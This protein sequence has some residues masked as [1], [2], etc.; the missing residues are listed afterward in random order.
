MPKRFGKLESRYQQGFTSGFNHGKNLLLLSTQIQFLRK[1]KGIT[2]EVFSKETNIPED[3]IVGLEKADLKT[4][5]RTELDSLVRIANFCDVTIDVKLKSHFD[6][7]HNAST[8]EVKSFEEEQSSVVFGNG[9]GYKLPEVFDGGYVVGAD[10]HIEHTLVPKDSVGGKS[11]TYI[12]PLSQDG[13]LGEYSIKPSAAV[14]DFTPNLFIVF[15][16]ES[17]GL[18]GQGFAVGWVVIEI[19]D[20]GCDLL[21][22]YCL[23]CDRNYAMGALDDRNWVN[24]NVPDLEVNV[25][26]LPELRTMFWNKFQEWKAK[27]AALVA[28][29]TW[30]VEARFLLDCVDDN[31]MGR[32]WEAPYPLYDL[33]SIL[34]MVGKNPLETFERLEEELPKHNP[35]KDAKQSARLLMECLNKQTNQFI[36]DLK[37]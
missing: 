31:P 34:F 26:S 29:C 16:V 21:E 17:I 8:V 19:T 10:T 28:D 1:K 25:N 5:M 15:D 23:S 33:S 24:E 13:T 32:K 30:P 11:V 2:T 7:E 4:Y 35:L 12:A 3:I 27:G 36:K 20:D 14:N 18:H 9:E 37:C 22:E 6:S